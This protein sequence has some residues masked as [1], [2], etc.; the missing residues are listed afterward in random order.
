MINRDSFLFGLFLITFLYSC[1]NKDVTIA[2]SSPAALLPECG[3]EVITGY[4]NKVSYFPGE[5][6]EVFLQSD[7]YRDCGLGLY[8]INGELVFRS[9]AALFHQSVSLEEPWKNGFG[10]KSSGKIIVPPWLK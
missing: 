8:N 6:I 3:D 7:K 10:F 4:T 9:K 1:E 2:P 5:E